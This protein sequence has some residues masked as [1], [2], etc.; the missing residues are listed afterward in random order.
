VRRSALAV[1]ETR[2]ISQPQAELFDASLLSELNADIDAGIK[3]ASVD[4]FTSPT[5]LIGENL[6]LVD[7][8]PYEMTVAG[9]TEMRVMFVL[10]RGNGELLYVPQNP[11]SSRDRFVDIYNKVRQANSVSGENRQLTITNVVFN[12]LEKGGRSGNKPI[13]LQFTKDTDKIWA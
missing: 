2:A 1:S 7:A 8:F 13:M 10:D 12:Q 11:N 9:E 6:N 4:Q 3:A 5:S